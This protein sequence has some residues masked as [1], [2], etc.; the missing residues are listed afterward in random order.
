MGTLNK[1]IEE[2]NADFNFGDGELKSLALTIDLDWL[3]QD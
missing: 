2:I 1:V 3:G